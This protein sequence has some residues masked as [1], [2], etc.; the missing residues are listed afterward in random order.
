MNDSSVGEQKVAV[1]TGVSSGI[2]QVLRQRLIDQ[3]WRVLGIS[4]HL[5]QDIEG[6]EA[7]LGFLSDVEPLCERI[8]GS[9]PKIDAFFHL[10]GVW[11]DE[12]ESLVGKKLS[13]FSANQIMMTMNVGVTSAMIMAARMAHA[14]PDGGQAVFL[15]GTFQDGGANWVPYYTSKRALEDFLVGFA[16]DET[17][18]MIVGVSPARMASSATHTY[19]SQEAVYAQS[20]E[21]V[22][23]I[24]LDIL[25]GKLGVSSGTVVEVRDGKPGM[26]YHE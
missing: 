6:F 13:E 12:K 20:P 21:S 2:G 9:A 8:L 17:R 16:A 14:M 18:L 11:H 4:R 23:D 7:D 25:A 26:G 5:P 3:G 15:S 19:A 10:A 1:M 24:C 22:A